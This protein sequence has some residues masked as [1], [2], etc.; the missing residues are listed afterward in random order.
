MTVRA[1]IAELLRAGYGD[2]T[3]ARQAGV[4]IGTV[5][6]AR[7]E[8]GLPKARGGI[9]AA[10][11]PEDLFWRRAQPVDG[12][13]FEWTGHRTNRGTPMLGWKGGHY[14]A[15]RVAYR[16]RHGQDPQGYAFVACDHPGCVAPGHVG[17]SATTA[18]PAHHHKSTGR[19]P[20]GSREDIVRLLNE[21]CSDKEIGRRLRTSARRAAA[22]RAELGLPA[23]TVPQPPTFAERWAAQTEPADGGHVRWTGSVR[24][25]N[26]PAMTEGGITVSAR[27]AAFEHL[28][29]R[30]A[31]GQVRP[32][33]GTGWCVRPDHLEDR[34]MRE[35]LANQYEAIFGVIAA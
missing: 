23:Y 29:G 6:R 24:D 10:G 28:H 16:I 34:P 9:K 11:S 13:H 17:D 21:G 27:R 3:I 1:D 30:R 7:A 35:R 26:S 15:L 18:R 25:G 31:V 19:Q 20:N 33:C 5:T 12:G 2:R 8:L 14:S 32:G 22:V 4:S